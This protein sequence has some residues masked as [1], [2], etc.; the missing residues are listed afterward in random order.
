[1]FD[2]AA[3][4]GY[5]LDPQLLA[6]AETRALAAALGDYGFGAIEPPEY[7]CPD[8]VRRQPVPGYCGMCRVIREAFPPGPSPFIIT[9]LT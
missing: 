7:F 6:W 1:M 3:Q 8:C 5:T 4:R 9:G 2:L